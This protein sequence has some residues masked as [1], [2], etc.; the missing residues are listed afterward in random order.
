MKTTVPPLARRASCLHPRA[1]RQGRHARDRPRVRRQECRPGRAQAHA[2]RARRRRRTSSAAESGCITPAHCRPLSLADITGRDSDGEFLARPT[3]WDEEAH[4][5]PPVIHIAV[6]RR[7]RPG[8]VAGVGDRALL[9]IE[10][11]D[12][13]GDQRPRHKTDRP[14]QA[15]RARYF[16]RPAGRR[17]PAGAD[18][19]E[20]ARP[21]DSRSPRATPAARRTAISS[22]SKWRATAGSACRPARS[23]SGSV[24]SRASGRSA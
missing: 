20:A 19:Q 11:T 9:R 10:Q 1:R 13:R 24:R 14:R 18:R 7:A 12:E 16:S 17:R 2:A 8:E 3:E 4:G 23:W 6:P 15:S 22:P 5:A 21:R